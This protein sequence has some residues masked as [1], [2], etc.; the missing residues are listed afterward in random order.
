MSERNA[1]SKNRETVLYTVI[2][3][4]CMCALIF[5]VY[6]FNIPNPNMILITAL[7]VATGLGGFWPGFVSALLM[8]IY[9]LYFFS[10]DHDFIHFSEVN[11][12]K[13]SVIFIGIILSFLCVFLLKRSRDRNRDELLETN[14]ALENANDSLRERAETAEHIAE[15]RQSVSS[16]LTNMP[17]LTFSKDVG[18]GV[19]L[20]CNQ[21]FAEFAGKSCPEEVVGLGDRDIFN[22]ETAHHFMED[23]QKALDMKEPYVFLETVTD[24]GGKKREMRTTKLKFIDPSGRLCLLGMCTDVTELAQAKHDSVTFSH[25]IQALSGDYLRLY[26]VDLDSGHFIEYIPDAANGTLKVFRE[27]D[28]FYEEAKILAEQMVVREDR[29]LFLNALKQETIVHDLNTKQNS[30]IVVRIILEDGSMIHAAVRISPINE[31]YY[32]VVIGVRN[33]E[34]QVKSREAQERMEQE[35]ESFLR[36]SALAGNY[37]A[38]YAVD[39]VTEHFIRYNATE[40][41]ESLQADSEGDCF[42]ESSLK[43]ADRVICPE[44]V[45]LF[46]REFTKDNVLKEIAKDGDFIL[47][48]RLMIEDGL[49][50]VQMRAVSVEEKDG[51]KLLIGISDID[52]LVRREAELSSRLEESNKIATR[53]ALTGVKNKYSYLTAKADLEKKIAEKECEGFAIGMFDT[54]DLKIT[55]DTIG[56]AAGDAYLRKAC[57]LICDV[58]THSPV[59]RIGGDEFA[60]IA[61]GHDYEN[62]EVLKQEMQ[63]RMEYSELTGIPI[64]ACGYAS[65]T[66]EDDVEAVFEK[67][68]SNMYEEKRRLKEIYFSPERR[69]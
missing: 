23:D 20:A 62:L 6:H 68:D 26:R 10:S 40:E 50:Y 35:R 8:G 29:E 43:N 69:D 31:E 41:Y 36:M 38:I 61:T 64:L 9:S 46:C 51:E 22:A 56:H 66:S 59:F 53:D 30:D 39:P 52:A 28:H 34:E 48:Y 47:R 3:A 19:Y 4:L 24:A 18:T 42:F 13:M 37:L 21:L 55:N 60:L 16:L 44:D 58:F 12:Q 15:L 33:I 65:G 54:N 5:I 27:T 45:P 11:A 63:E 2:A 14:R 7:V 57:A 49:K 32:D 67:A 17:A 25:I 1:Q